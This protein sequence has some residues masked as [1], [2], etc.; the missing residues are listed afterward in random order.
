M[1]MST[2]SNTGPESEGLS[3]DRF[4]RKMQRRET[5][6]LV[7]MSFFLFNAVGAA[8]FSA[9]IWMTQELAPGF[10]GPALL[11]EAISL[12]LLAMLWRRTNRMRRLGRVS[13]ATTSRFVVTALEETRRAMREQ[14]LVAGAVGLVLTPSF[15]L[16]GWRLVEDGRMA[17]GDLASVAIL[18][19][20]GLAVVLGVSWHRLRRDLG[21]RERVLQRLN[22]ELGD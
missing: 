14:R 5:L 3:V 20:V 12:A 21:P 4:V 1:T 2:G 16:A 11:V 15:L 19:A 8:V 18:Y 13:A 22:S 7:L 6:R 9:W 17:T 10:L